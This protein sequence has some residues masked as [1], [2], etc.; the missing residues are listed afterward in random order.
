MSDEMALFR[1]ICEINELDPQVIEEAA[2]AHRPGKPN[3]VETLIWTAFN[4]RAHELVK[5]AGLI[6]EE[7][8]AGLTDKKAYTID[9]DPAAPS[10]KV[11]EDFIRSKYAE[12]EAEKL[13]QALGQVRLPVSG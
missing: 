10:F 4:Y 13:V 12:E 8:K 3:E 11:N 2:V 6:S 1:Q 5:E 7:N 9:C